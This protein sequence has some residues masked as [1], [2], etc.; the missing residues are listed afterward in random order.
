MSRPRKRNRGRPRAIKIKK[1]QVAKM[2]IDGDWKE[3]L[4]TELEELTP[5]FGLNLVCGEGSIEFPDV[6]PTPTNSENTQDRSVESDK[7]TKLKPIPSSRNV[8]LFYCP[9]CDHT[10]PSER[11]IFRHINDKHIRMLVYQCPICGHCSTQSS[12]SA[13]H[14][15]DRH[16]ARLDFTKDNKEYPILISGIERTVKLG[17]IASA[18]GAKITRCKPADLRL[19]ASLFN[20]DPNSRSP[21]RN[22]IT[23]DITKTESLRISERLRFIAMKKP[24][25]SP[26]RKTA[27]ATVSRRARLT[28]KEQ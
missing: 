2:E 7:K 18:N 26:T 6:T 5:V 22:Q 24:A 17:R 3:P 19:I 9:V 4:F 12:N 25:Q 14:A 28:N 15:K 27:S 10:S 16:K 20:Y 21:S 13:T 23:L 11:N 1:R 8:S